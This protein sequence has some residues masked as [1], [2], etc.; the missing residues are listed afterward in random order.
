MESLFNQNNA[1]EKDLTNMIVDK[2][3]NTKLQI[4]SISKHNRCII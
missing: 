4:I 2:E 3:H 1:F